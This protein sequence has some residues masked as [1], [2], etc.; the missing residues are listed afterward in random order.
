MVKTMIKNYQQIDIY[1][2]GKDYL[3]IYFFSLLGGVCFFI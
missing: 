1:E 3:L 2:E